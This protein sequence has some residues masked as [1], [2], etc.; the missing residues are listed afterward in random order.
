MNSLHRYRGKVRTLTG[1]KYFYPLVTFLLPILI[2]ICAYAAMEV[3]PFGDH[4]TAIID[5]YHQYVP[6]FAELHDKIWHGDSLL[7]SWHGGLGFNFWR[8]WPTT[9]LPLSICWLPSFL[10][11]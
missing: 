5:S 9:W 1:K 4:A 7:Y 2:M 8:S 3:W 11:G 10:P 6:F